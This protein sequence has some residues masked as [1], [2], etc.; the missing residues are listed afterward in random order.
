M[1]GF[2]NLKNKVAII[3]GGTK[4][5]G[6]AISVAFAQAGANVIVCSRTPSECI[7]VSQ[8]LSQYNKDCRGISVDIT[9]SKDIEK[10]VVRVMDVFGRIDALVN[11]AGTDFWMPAVEVT[12]D[13]WDRVLDVNLKGQ[14]FC[15]QAIGRQMIQQKKG[16]IINI[17]SILG[18]IGE[19]DCSVY[20]ITKGGVNQLTRALAIEWAPYNIQVNAIAPGYVATELTEKVMDDEKAAK[21]IMRKTPLK[22]L[23][24]PDEV[25]AGAVYLASEAANYITGQILHIDGGWTVQ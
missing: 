9:D 13:I 6:Y 20:A 12:R 19:M 23:G 15:A 14:F 25:A 3:T 5:L 2:A 4:G 22:R 11:N 24:F 7:A 16:K 8:E 17:S 10:L 18:T 1:L 21:Y